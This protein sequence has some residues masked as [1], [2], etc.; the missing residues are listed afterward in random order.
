MPF[1]MIHKLVFL[2]LEIYFE[3]FF[4]LVFTAG[5]NIELFLLR[6]DC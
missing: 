1:E 5:H 4:C 6:R 2:I 3:H